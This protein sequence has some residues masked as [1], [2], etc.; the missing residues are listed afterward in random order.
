[1]EHFQKIFTVQFETTNSHFAI[2]ASITHYLITL[3]FKFINT[4]NVVLQ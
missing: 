2:I 1:M 3:L 4:Y